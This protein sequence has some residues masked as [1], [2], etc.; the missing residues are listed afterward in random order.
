MI[1]F[2]NTQEPLILPLTSQNPSIFLYNSEKTH[3]NLNKIYGV[4]LIDSSAIS[5][6]FHEE[7]NVKFEFS[8]ENNEKTCEISQDFDLNFERIF[9]IKLNHYSNP[10]FSFSNLLLKNLSFYAFSLK[11]LYLDSKFPNNPL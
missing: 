5:S 2:T 1:F 4:L 3:K 10:L 7:I 9:E 11:S 6:N 8:N